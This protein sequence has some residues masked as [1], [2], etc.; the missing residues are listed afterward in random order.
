MRTFRLLALGLTL[1]GS[2][3]AQT[4]VV[5]W[6]FFAGGD[7]ARMKQIVDA[8]NASQTDIKVERTTQTWGNPFYTKVHTAVVAG[9]TPDVMTYHLSAAPAGLQRRDLRLITPADL[10][11][12]GLKP[13]DFQGNLISSLNTAAKNAG[14]SGLYGIPL[15]THTFVLYYN[16]DLLRKAG[17]L[18][19]SGTLAPMK[20]VA[21]LTRTLQAIKTKTG[22]TPIAL[23]SNQDSASVWRLW[24][25]LF[26]QQGGT[27]VRG[28]KLSTTDLNTKGLAAL[29]IMADW[30]RQGLITKNV[31][32]PAGV[33]LFTAGRAATMLNGN[34]EVPTMVDATAKG[35][36]KFDY[37][38]M[39]FPA[40]YGNAST[41]ADSHLLAIPTNAKTPM[42]AAK[43]KAVMTF[44]GYVNKQG[45]TT[46]AGGGHIPAYLPTQASAA[47]KAMQPNTQY[48]ATSAADARLEPSAPIFGVGG[49][50]YDAIGVNFT[51]VLLGQTTPEQGIAKLTTALNGF[52]K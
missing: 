5:F 51:P 39:S 1:A 23:S 22:V 43:L 28:G 17:V 29:R 44:I 33:A 41:W 49:P 35:Q 34:W 6:D 20:T 31:T 19:A 52:A 11:L 46:W 12:G 10:A 3:H 30:S 9:Q 27:L 48:S 38:I 50:V 8:F 2:A 37:G 40:L 18:S 36:L 25:S 26:L 32:Y 14:S 24:Y 45:G 42:D 4:K 7:G 13:A 21:D 47:F 15:D 16:K